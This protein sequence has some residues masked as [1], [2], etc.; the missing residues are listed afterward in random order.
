MRVQIPVCDDRILSFTVDIVEASIPL[1]HGLDVLD[2]HAIF[3]KT[4]TNELFFAQEGWNLPLTRMMWHV[5]LEWVNDVLYSSTD[6][7]KIYR[8]FYRPHRDRIYNLM[9]RAEDPEATP[10]THRSL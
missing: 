6:R 7:V 8:H 5:Y 10:E 1:L 3:S 4:V 9:R 2:Q